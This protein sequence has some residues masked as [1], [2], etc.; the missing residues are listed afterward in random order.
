VTTPA[1]IRCRSKRPPGRP[2]WLRSP[3][4]LPPLRRIRCRRASGASP[5]DGAFIPHF[6]PRAGGSGNLGVQLVA[7]AVRAESPSPAAGAWSRG[8]PHG[9]WKPITR[10]SISAPAGISTWPPCNTSEATRLRKA[11]PFSLLVVES[12]SSSR[13][14]CWCLR[15]VRRGAAA[16]MHNV[17]VR[18][19]GVVRWVT[20]VAGAQPAGALCRPATVPPSGS[21]SFDGLSGAAGGAT[22]L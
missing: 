9:R 22:A 20:A 4:R 18:I 3:L 2:G 14:E 1:P 12:R 21:G 5:A 6:G 16:R 15:E 19:G 8:R 17:A 7:R 11:S 10:P 13:R